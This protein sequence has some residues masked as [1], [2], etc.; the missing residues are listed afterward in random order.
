MFEI[1]KWGDALAVCMLC[2]RRCGIDR[3]NGFGYC[4]VGSHLRVA[5]AML[6]FGEE[7]CITGRSGS[8]AVF[9][10]GCAL[11][12]CFCQNQD[13]S[14][15]A[16]GL[17]I[18]PERLGQ[19]FL[20]LQEQG[21]ENLNLVTPSHYAPQIASV[22]RILKRSLKIPI[23]CNC[24][25]YESE[26]ILSCF[27]G[28]IDVYLPDLKYASPERSARYSS[29]PD[30]FSVAARA[31]PEMFRQTGAC[32]FDRNGLLKQGLLIRHLVLPGG[33]KDSIELLRWIA[34]TFP[35]GSVRISLMRQYT[36]CGDL[37]ACPELRRSVFSIEYDAVCR[38]AVRLG[39][40]GYI[41]GK[42][43]NTLEMTPVFDLSGVRKE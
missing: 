10:C 29:A 15:G 11:R 21:A 6:H 40:E 26:E 28:L 17:E 34:D 31:L 3:E 35:P 12:C 5:R 38:E 33:R 27:E 37:S 9:F 30:Y 22:L 8:G 41:Q 14:R 23:V 2:P 24:G 42:G 43:C 4:G 25:G 39:L 19:I 1:Q 36:P 18:S 7:P 20:E 32:R 13:I 16:A